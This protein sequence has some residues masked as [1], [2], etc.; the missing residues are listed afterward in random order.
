[1]PDFKTQA[2]WCC[3]TERGWQGTIDGHVVRW[4]R[5]APP[6]RV[7]FGFTC[8]CKGYQFRKSCRH[9]KAA[10]TMRCGWNQF[11]HGGEPI[12]GRCPKCGGEVTA[13]NYAV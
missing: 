3:E 6:A 1:M 8:D 5:L 10:E 2:F 9:I 12:D 7:Q 4:E 11:V 13:E